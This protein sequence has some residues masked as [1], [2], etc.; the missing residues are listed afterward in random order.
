MHVWP[1]GKI[2]NNNY[3]TF[4]WPNFLICFPDLEDY[5]YYSYF[6]GRWV[7]VKIYLLL[8]IHN[9]IWSIPENII[10]NVANSALADDSEFPQNAHC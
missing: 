5:G 7:R 3:F 4:L 10:K 2:N 6:I 9:I 8:F 1:T